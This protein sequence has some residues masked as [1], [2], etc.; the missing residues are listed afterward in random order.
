MSPQTILIVG[1]GVAGPALATFLLLSPLPASEKPHITLLERSTT[2]SVNGQNIDVRGAGVTIIRKLGLEN[3]IRSSTT[4]EEGVQIVD[5]QN[6]VCCSLAADKSGK[7]Q[8]PTSDIEIMRG[9]LAEIL[10]HRCENVSE[11]V[12]KN[13]GLGVEFVF[14]ESIEEV[15][16]DGEKVNVR[17]SKSE[18]KRSFDVVVG[19][20]GLQSRT[21][22]LVWGE[23]GEAERVKRLGMYAGFF[24]LPK[25]GADTLWRRWYHAPGRKGIMLRPD[26]QRGR[27]TAMMHVINEKDERFVD[28]AKKGPKGVDEQKA[29][30]E[31]YFKTVGWESER[32]IREMWAT[33]DFY[34]DMVAQV[35]MEKF[36][37][38]RVVLL[39]DAG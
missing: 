8:T 36:S 39:G 10:N 33:R 35:K 27:T 37:K 18:V 21:R 14:G 32:V 7:L 30:L 15:E 11:Q 22:K 17:F 16:Q 23:D 6:R 4:G 19:A 34:Y 24:S 26:E 25:G 13:G 9:R 29:L 38:G 20:D 12:K 1:A 28:V 3:L 5:E 2:I 31:E